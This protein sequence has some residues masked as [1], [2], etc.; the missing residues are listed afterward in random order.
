M[1][2]KQPYIVPYCHEAVEILY[3]DDTLLFVNKPSTLLSVPGR[4]P[5][6]KDCLI[7]RIQ[8]DYPSARIVHRLDMDTSGVMVLAL[9]AESHRHLS[10][11]FEQRKT[12][13]T[14]EAVVQ[15][16]I[17]KEQGKIDLPIC[18]DW[19]NRPKQKVDYENGK[20]ALTHFQVLDSDQKNNATR[21]QLKPVTGRSHQ[22]RI[23]LSS[24]GHPILGCSFYGNEQSAKRLLLHANELRVQHPITGETLQGKSPTPF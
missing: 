9:N 21:V 13:K 7:S 16:L 22:L 23:H 18:C 19:P 1:T 12:R 24:I 15:G 20:Q 17:E 8:Q 10:L 2:S 5:D 4:H 6:N 11:Q 14:Y 3:A